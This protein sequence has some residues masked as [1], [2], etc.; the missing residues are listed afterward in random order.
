MLL[1]HCC[2]RFDARPAVTW[3]R[4][5]TLA[6]HLDR[7]YYPSLTDYSSNALYTGTAVHF[8]VQFLTVYL[9]VFYISI[10][11]R[12]VCVLMPILHAKMGIVYP[13]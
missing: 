8:P 6:I 12:T 7:H 13:D 5:L 2:M 10:A 1:L 9:V 3:T 4:I 11:L